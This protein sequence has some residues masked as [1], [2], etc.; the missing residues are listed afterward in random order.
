MLKQQAELQHTIGSRVYR[1]LCDNDAPTHEI[2][3]SLCRFIHYIGQIEDH[4][5]AQQR[6]EQDQKEAAAEPQAT[7]SEV[8]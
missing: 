6:Q 8:A 1:L 3:E 5:I 7:E 2:K 4:A